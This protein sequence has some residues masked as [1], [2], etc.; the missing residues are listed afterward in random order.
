MLVVF[1]LRWWGALQPRHCA[2]NWLRLYSWKPIETRQIHLFL[3]GNI[4]KIYERHLTRHTRSLNIVSLSDISFKYLSFV[5]NN[6]ENSFRQRL[7]EESLQRNKFFII[8][9]TMQE[10]RRGIWRMS[11]NWNFLS[12]LYLRDHNRK[13]HRV[14]FFRKLLSP[15]LFQSESIVGINTRNRD[16]ERI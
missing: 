9:Q 7:M 4:K 8:S 14:K 16:A 3:I 2:F 11:E 12:K 5:R 1:I 6:S 15:M 13:T 10:I